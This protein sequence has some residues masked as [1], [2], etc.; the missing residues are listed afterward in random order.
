M[1]FQEQCNKPE[2]VEKD[3][4]GEKESHLQKVSDIKEKENKS[5]A[6]KLQNIEKKKKKSASVATCSNK[7][8]KSNSSKRGSP[9]STMSEQEFAL[10]KMFEQCYTNI[11]ERFNQT[12]ADTQADTTAITAKKTIDLVMTN[13][14][15]SLQ[16]FERPSSVL[17]L[18]SEQ[19]PP[20]AMLTRSDVR[21]LDHVNDVRDPKKNGM[22]VDGTMSECLDDLDI[23]ST[24]SLEE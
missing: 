24:N 13:V 10:D 19:P 5:V 14:L 22:P 3:I 16:P 2:E 18:P 1:L 7:T 12:I 21:L 23:E 17:E 20:P 9:I 11:N 6:K 4:S 15:S 8:L